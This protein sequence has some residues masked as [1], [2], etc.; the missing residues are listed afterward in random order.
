MALSTWKS[1]LSSPS[2]YLPNILCISAQ[3]LRVFPSAPGQG[4]ISWHY[5]PL[6]S[7]YYIFTLNYTSF[8]GEYLV[9]ILCPH[10]TVNNMRVQ[11]LFLYFYC[12]LNYLLHNNYKKKKKICIEFSLRDHRSKNAD[13]WLGGRGVKEADW[14][15]RSLIATS[16]KA[17]W[18]SKY[19]SS[20]V[21]DMER[22]SYKYQR[23][24]SASETNFLVMFMLTGDDICTSFL[25]YHV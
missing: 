19:L 25:A 5:I 15:N 21:T 13:R 18:K 16:L 24:L 17:N 12:L 11:S 6:P 14:D 20:C 9:T 7:T 22:E 8:L 4:W 23:T 10:L 3:F 2:S 1:F